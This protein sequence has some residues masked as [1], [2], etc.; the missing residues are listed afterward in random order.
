[1]FSIQVTLHQRKKDRFNEENDPG[2]GI[3]EF[4]QVI[5]PRLSSVILFPYLERSSSKSNDKLKVEICCYKGND[6]L[7]N[8]TSKEREAWQ[9]LFMHFDLTLMGKIN[10]SFS[11]P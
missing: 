1:M 3:L 7:Y 5:L 2:D 8:C 10:I 6:R 11:I 4:W 9:V